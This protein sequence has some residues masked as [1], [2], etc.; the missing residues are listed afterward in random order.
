MKEYFKLKLNSFYYLIYVSTSSIFTF[1]LRINSVL[2]VLYH[3]C[4]YISGLSLLLYLEDV[5][6]L[7][8]FAGRWRTSVIWIAAVLGAL[9]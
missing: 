2:P 1:L 7:L 4:Q 6:L 9:L 8:I 3:L 5:H